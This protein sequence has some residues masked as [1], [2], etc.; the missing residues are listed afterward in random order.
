MQTTSLHT[1]T[2]AHRRIGEGEIQ[3]EKQIFYRSFETIEFFKKRKKKQNTKK[4]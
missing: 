3:T 1:Y 4:K 2:Q